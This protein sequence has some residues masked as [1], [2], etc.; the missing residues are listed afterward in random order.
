[1]VVFD[2]K[3]FG[4]RAVLHVH[5]RGGRAAGPPAA[6]GQSERAAR[7]RLQT[8]PAVS[9]KSPVFVLSLS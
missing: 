1:M 5:M 6:R 2:N 8:S 4:G 3:T 7:L 9:F